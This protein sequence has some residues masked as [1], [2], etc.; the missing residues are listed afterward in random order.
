MPRERKIILE[1]GVFGWLFLLVFL[2]GYGYNDKIRKNSY[3]R[4][5]ESCDKEVLEH[6]KRSCTHEFHLGC[7]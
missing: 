1:K 7:H 2:L 3:F 4:E 6:G 5:N